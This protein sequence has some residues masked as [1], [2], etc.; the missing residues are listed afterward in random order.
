MSEVTAGEVSGNYAKSRQHT[1]KVIGGRT[2]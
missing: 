1:A 2:A